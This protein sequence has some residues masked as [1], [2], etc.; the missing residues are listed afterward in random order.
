[1]CKKSEKQKREKKKLNRIF[2]KKIKAPTRLA[3]SVERQTFTKRKFQQSNLVVEG[4]SPSS[5][6][7]SPTGQK[8]FVYIYQK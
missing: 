7:L 8:Q 2:A 3:Q 1:M 5:G 4:S 6:V